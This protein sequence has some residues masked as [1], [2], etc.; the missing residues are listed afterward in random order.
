[1]EK[2]RVEGCRRSVRTGGAPCLMACETIG[3]LIDDRPFHIMSCHWTGYLPNLSGLLTQPPNQ[4]LN[5]LSNGFFFS[6]HLYHGSSGYPPCLPVGYPFSRFC[7]RGHSLRLQQ[8]S[9][10]RKCLDR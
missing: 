5:I 2:P 3:I 7:S 1:M 9:S 6:C 4:Q 8:G 10:Q